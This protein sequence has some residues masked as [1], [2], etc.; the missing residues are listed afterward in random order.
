[1]SLEEY[2]KN[3]SPKLE[4]AVAQVVEGKA[5]KVELHEKG[6]INIYFSSLKQL[7]EVKKGG[8]N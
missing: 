3:I 1:M 5:E 7:E 2:Q 4:K 8:K 6:F